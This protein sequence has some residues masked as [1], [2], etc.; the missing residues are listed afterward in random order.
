MAYE[1]YQQKQYDQVYE[2]LMDTKDF[3]DNKM[4]DLKDQIMLV[5]K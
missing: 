1:E 2:E 3:L 4:K 5:R